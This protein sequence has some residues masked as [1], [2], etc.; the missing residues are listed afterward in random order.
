MSICWSVCRM[1]EVA[2]LT[3]LTLQS[4][5]QCK[6]FV[7]HSRTCWSSVISASVLTLSMDIVVR[8]RLCYGLFT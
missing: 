4:S 1:L 2:V 7:K 8:H 6:E 5:Q 3:L